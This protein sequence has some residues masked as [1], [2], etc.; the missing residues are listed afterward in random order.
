M[1]SMECI[2]ELCKSADIIALQETWFF[3]EDIPL[4]GTKDSDFDFTGVSSIYTTAGLLRGRPYGGVA[5][6]WRKS[7]F[8]EINLVNCHSKR[9]TA[10]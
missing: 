7:A 6:L 1:R 9:F 10:I 2:V 4:L 8:D 3:P 5:L